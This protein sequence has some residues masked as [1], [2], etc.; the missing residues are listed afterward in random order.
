LDKLTELMVNADDDA[1]NREEALFT[2]FL[3][4]GVTPGAIITQALQL[5]TDL[6]LKVDI[7]KSRMPAAGVGVGAP[8]NV[9]PGAVLPQIKLPPLQLPDFDGRIITGSHF[10]N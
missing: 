2:N 1:R 9:N 8:P 6:D 7:I 10:G 5:Q 4:G 3:I